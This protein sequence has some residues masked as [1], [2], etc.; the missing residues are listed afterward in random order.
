MKNPRY[1]IQDL[2]YPI[3]LIKKSK[4]KFSV[5]YGQQEDHNLTYPEAACK[6]GEAIM[7]ALQ[8]KGKLD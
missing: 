6:L 2:A 8:C 1:I 7:H 4:N 5:I 3:S